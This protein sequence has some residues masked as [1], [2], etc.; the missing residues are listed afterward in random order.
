M[1]ASVHFSSFKTF[2]HLIK[3]SI[4]SFYQF[5]G[6]FKRST[7]NKRIIVDRDIIFHMVGRGGIEP[8]SQ[9]TT[10]LQTADPPRDLFTPQMFFW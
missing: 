1:L 4:N 9:M 7:N 8:L 3:R 10:V 2:T 5:F 6:F